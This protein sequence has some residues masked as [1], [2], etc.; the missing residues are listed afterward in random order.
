MQKLLNYWLERNH[1][2]VA[3]RVSQLLLLV[4][5]LI[6]LH[7][8]AAAE[9]IRLTTPRGAMVE[10]IVDLPPGEGPF[11]ALVLAPGQ[12]YHMALPALQETSRRLV[13]HGVA[14]YRFNWAYFTKNPNILEPSS[15]LSNELQDLQTV[16]SLARANPRIA[17]QN[18]FIGG[19]SLGSLVAWR[20]LVKDNS[21]HGGLFLTP[22]CVDLKSSE[23]APNAEINYPGLSEEH[24][25]IAFIAG[26]HDPLCSPPVL[27]R[28]ASKAGGSARVAIVGGDH[29]FETPRLTGSAQA[30]ASERSIA[31][32][33]DF[34][35]NF[36]LDNVV[37]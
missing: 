36:I 14:V 17:Q 6:V 34:A 16:I 20:A 21:I 19:K 15:D 12:G 13:T 24:R 4:I 7:G 2:T 23:A 27:Y 3:A 10:V 37:H 18:L 30:N 9:S 33:G 31:A 25:P 1:L 29:S 11:P 26:D 8:P 28:F 35:V 32:V 5:L 22:V